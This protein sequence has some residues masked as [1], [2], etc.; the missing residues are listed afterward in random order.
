MQLIKADLWDCDGVLCLTTNGFVKRNGRAVMGAGV[1]R[2]AVLRYPG[3]DAELGRLIKR[4]GNVVQ[5]IAG[6]GFNVEAPRSIVSFP[7]KH[8]WWENATLQLIERSAEQ[9]AER[10]DS[11]IHR[12]CFLPKPGC[13]NG[14]LDWPD[15]RD[16][17]E[18]FLGSY[19]NLYIVDR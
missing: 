16:T 1:A 4:N 12:D 9:L 13:G 19:D 3:I 15:V 18:P 17:L 5:R 10:L 14:G 8:D 11:R 6:P 2:Q 7:V